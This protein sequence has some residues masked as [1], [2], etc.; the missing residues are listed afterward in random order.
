MLVLRSLRLPQELSHCIRKPPAPRLLTRSARSA[1]LI[2][3]APQRWARS[4]RR[5]PVRLPLDD[6]PVRSGPDSRPLREISVEDGLRTVPADP[7]PDALGDLELRAAETVTMSAAARTGQLEET[8]LRRSRSAELRPAVG[9]MG[10]FGDDE[11]DLP[12]GPPEP[13][14]GPSDRSLWPVGAALVVGIALGF[15]GGY[16]FG[17]RHLRRA[18]APAATAPPGREWTEG[19]VN[20]PAGETP[21]VLPSRPDSSSRGGPAAQPEPGATVNPGNAGPHRLRLTRAGYAD[22]DRRSVTE[23]ALSVD[24][25]PGGARVFVDGKLIGTTPISVPQVGAG[26]HA[27]RLERDGYRRWSSS[28]RMIAGEPNRVTASLEK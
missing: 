6:A 2:R 7:E 27:I 26:A 23:T 20:E 10:L 14:E 12:E 4:E 8:P 3:S 25:R 1:S 22:G 28:I 15:G 16:T 19:A 17:G 5:P 18:P 13:S 11:R 21:S 24:S 9:V